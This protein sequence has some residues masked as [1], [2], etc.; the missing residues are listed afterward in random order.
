MSASVMLNQYCCGGIVEIK[1]S[2]I[3]MHVLSVMPTMI[4]GPARV[5]MHKN[6]LMLTSDLEISPIH[7]KF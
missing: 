1:L 3:L 2:V 7:T 6:F 5:F 4:K